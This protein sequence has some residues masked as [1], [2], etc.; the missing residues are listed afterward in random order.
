MAWQTANSAH[1][2]CM[3]PPGAQ[4]GLALAHVPLVVADDCLRDIDTAI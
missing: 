2:S 4:D 3:T 1:I